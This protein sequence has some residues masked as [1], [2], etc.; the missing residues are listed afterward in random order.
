MMQEFYQ[1][2]LDYQAK[3]DHLKHLI[4]SHERAI[5]KLQD[6]GSW[7]DAVVKPLAREISVRLG[8][9]TE[10]PYH[11]WKIY[12]PFGLG[13]ETT[14]YFFCTEEHNIV[15]G[16][17]YSLTLHPNFT[18]AGLR[19]TYNTGEKNDNYAPGSI[20]WLNGFNNVE[21]PLPDSIEE[22]M[23]LLTHNPAKPNA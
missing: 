21:A 4:E 13:N 15:K 6:K 23:K 14:I 7:I 5:R 1:N 20:G 22:I 16:E 2:Y 8:P 18:D 3:I 9:S 11:D 19:L 12:G 17:T 10:L